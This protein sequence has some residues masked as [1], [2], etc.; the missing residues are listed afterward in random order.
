MD[1]AVNYLAVLGAGVS[2][3]VIGALWYGPLFQKPW[4]RLAGL[5]T[6]SMKSMALSPLM[7]MVG[8][9]IISLLIAYVLS[10]A[11]V[12]VTAY[13]GTAGLF[14]GA[15]VGFWTWL[16]FLVPATSGAYLWEGKSPKLWV[17]NAG[18]YLV[19]LL[20]MGALLGAFPA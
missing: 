2:A 1:I 19:S 3:V 18:Y 17:L 20:V 11:V 13:T 14:A 16:G 5:T 8:G 15:E 10:Y 4:M 9:F 12:F 7:A 6:E